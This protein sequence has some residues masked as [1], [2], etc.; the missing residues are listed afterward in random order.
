MFLPRIP[1]ERT[2]PKLCASIQH[3]HQLQPRGD[4]RYRMVGSRFAS[5][6]A[7]QT[8][9]IAG[10]NEPSAV[11]GSPLFPISTA[12]NCFIAVVFRIWVSTRVIA[13]AFLTTTL[14]FFHQA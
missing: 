13:P 2:D 3:A 4:E 7:P 1:P 6:I 12:K 14:C 8:F 10:L 9:R 5:L 11:F